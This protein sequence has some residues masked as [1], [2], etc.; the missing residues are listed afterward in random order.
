MN[1]VKISSFAVVG[2][3]GFMVDA[4]V[5]YFSYQVVQLD[6]MIARIIAFLF[7]ATATWLGNRWFTFQSANKA[8]KLNQWQRFLFVATI[9]AVPNF[10]VFNLVSKILSAEPV[11]VYI[12]LVSG[13]LVGMLSN[14]ILSDRWVFSR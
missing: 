9:S 2:C 3:F 8:K 5:F 6:L 10:I 4:S 11:G 14:F 12:A 1:L 7:A 13:V